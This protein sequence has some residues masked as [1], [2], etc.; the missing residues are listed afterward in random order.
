MH[1]RFADLGAALRNSARQPE[2]AR[3]ADAM[4]GP[5]RSNPPFP[6]LSSDTRLFRVVS[7]FAGHSRLARPYAVSGVLAEEHS[8]DRRPFGGMRSGRRR[9]PRL[10]VPIG[11]IVG[12]AF[13]AV[14]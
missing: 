3:L 13:E 6:C 2:G 12:I 1:R 10:T 4:R 8:R 11:G 5:G 9:P 14:Q 7:W